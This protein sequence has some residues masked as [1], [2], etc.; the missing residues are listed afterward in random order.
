MIFI[1]YLACIIA[2]LTIRPLLCAY[3][4]LNGGAYVKTLYAGLY[5]FPIAA[6]IHAFLGGVVCKYWKFTGTFKYPHLLW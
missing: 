3:F 6:V 5:F 1:F 4:G 2:L